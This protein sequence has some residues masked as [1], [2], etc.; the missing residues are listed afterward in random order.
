MMEPE[1]RIEACDS[2][3]CHVTKPSYLAVDTVVNVLDVV[4]CIRPTARQG[5][6]KRCIVR[7]RCEH[8][9]REGLNAG[10]TL[11]QDS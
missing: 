10:E 9:I 8:L 11:G 6:R 4:T 7:R 3:V 2:G 5:A 1:D